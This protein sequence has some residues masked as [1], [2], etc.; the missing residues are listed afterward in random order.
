MPSPPWARRRKHGRWQI[1]TSPT[2][3]VEVSIA[4][5]WHRSAVAVALPLSPLPKLKIKGPVNTENSRN[6]ERPLTESSASDAHMNLVFG[7]EI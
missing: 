6:Q 1:L 3:K 2:L 7:M 4:R 5:K